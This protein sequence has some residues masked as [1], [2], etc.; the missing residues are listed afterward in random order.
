MTK[1]SIGCRQ[2]LWMRPIRLDRTNQGAGIAPY[3]AECQES[4]IANWFSQWAEKIF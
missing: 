3:Y 4:G 2:F 1:E